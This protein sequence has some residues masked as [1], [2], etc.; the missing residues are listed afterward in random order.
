MAK[1]YVGKYRQ[2]YV[3]IYKHDDYFSSFKN[4]F[5]IGWKIDI[6]VNNSDTYPFPT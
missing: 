1:K 5:P 2:R 4:R 6:F 3:P